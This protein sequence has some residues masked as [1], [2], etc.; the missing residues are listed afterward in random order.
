MIEFENYNKKFDDLTT[1]ANAISKIKLSDAERREALKTILGCI[2]LTSLEGNDTNVKIFS[3]CQHAQTFENKELGIANVAAVCFY[4]VFTKLAREQLKGTD[5]KVASVAGGFP[6]GL[7]PAEIKEAEVKFAVEEGADEVDVVIS[8]GFILANKCKEAYDQILGMRK[9]AGDA[10][11]KVILETGELET[12]F[13][14]RRASEVAINGGADFIKTST[15]K[16]QQGAT[17][18]AVLVMLD[19]IKEYHEKSGKMVGIKPSGGISEPDD[20]LLYYMLVKEVLGEKWLNKSYFRIG[21]SKL[22]HKIA[23]IL[24]KQD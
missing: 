12:V 3:V 9:A 16:I 11:M 7:M 4:S 21:A 23:A 5:I 10:T 18:E 13:K 19:T 1:R 20:A 6:S 2:D 17:P 14:I 22:A 8:R 15:G 24:R